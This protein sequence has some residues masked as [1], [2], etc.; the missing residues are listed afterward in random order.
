MP[1]LANLINTD[2]SQ[3]FTVSHVAQKHGWTEPMSAQ[4]FTAVVVSSM[5]KKRIL[6]TTTDFVISI[7]KHLFFWTL[8]FLSFPQIGE[9]PTSILRTLPVGRPVPNPESLR[10]NCSWA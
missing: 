6:G 1:V 3:G 5:H 8:S 2:L 10:Q 4:R 9:P 7:K